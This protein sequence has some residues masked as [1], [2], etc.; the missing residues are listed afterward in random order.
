MTEQ[1]QRINRFLVDAFHSLL[2]C[3]GR[4]LQNGS[5]QN[6][7]ISEIHTL[8]VIGDLAQ[9]EAPGSMSAIAERLSITTGTLTVSVN[10]LQRKGYV[11]R[12]RSKPDLRIVRVTLTG[13][14]QRAYDEHKAF[15]RSLVRYLTERLSPSDLKGL[16]ATLDLIERFFSA[17][18]AT[19]LPEE[20]PCP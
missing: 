8:E 3:E 14:G 10:T 17:P 7:S 16:T 15:H 11:T 20:P 9:G 4:A 18:D 5:F 13:L 6:L 12:Q 2:R 1:E 19:T